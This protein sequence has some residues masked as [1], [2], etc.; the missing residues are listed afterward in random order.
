VEYSATIKR[1]RNDSPLNFLDR[2]SCAERQDGGSMDSGR[3]NYGIDL[4]GCHKGADSIMNDD[5]IRGRILFAGNGR[6]FDAIECVENRVGAFVP[7]FNKVKV[8]RNAMTS[9]QVLKAVNPV[10]RKRHP[11]LVD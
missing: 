1:P 3:V 5:N 2:V 7:A 4:F 8:L 9:G 6:P 11:D 10:G